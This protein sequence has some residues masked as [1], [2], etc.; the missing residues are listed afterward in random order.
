MLDVRALR[1]TPVMSLTTDVGDIDI[2]DRVGGV[3]TYEDAVAASEKVHIGATEFRSLT[4]PALI[5]AK[6]A[7]GRPRDYEH[8]IELEALLAMRRK[9]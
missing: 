2:F 9:G 5:A 6:R 4:L 8:L 1:I 7:A 3:G